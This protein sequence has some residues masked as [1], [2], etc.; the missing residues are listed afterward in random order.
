MSDSYGAQAHGRQAAAMQLLRY[1]LVF[2]FTVAGSQMVVAVC[3]LCLAAAA[4][5]YL[6]CTMLP[7]IHFPVNQ[8]MC[9]GAF[10]HAWATLCA[11][12]MVVRGQPEVWEGPRELKLCS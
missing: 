7:Y 10:V 2:V 8:Y 12:V 11:A 5:L 9:A 3:A 6:H 1:A 4:L